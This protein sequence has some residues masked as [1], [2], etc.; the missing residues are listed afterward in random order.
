MEINYTAK[1]GV[2]YKI[3]VA[4]EV[5]GKKYNG[6]V[7]KYLQDI[8]KNFSDGITYFDTLSFYGDEENDW[9]LTVVE[10]FVD[11]LDLTHIKVCLDDVIDSSDLE[12]GSEFGY[13][14][15]E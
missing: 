9:Y 12:R 13:F 3:K 2:G 8:I 15:Y 10:P 5:V 1:F 6:D 14:I 4:K 11:G 7:S